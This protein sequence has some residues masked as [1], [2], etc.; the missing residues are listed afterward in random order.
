L[1]INLTKLVNDSTVLTLTKCRNLSRF[2]LIYLTWHWKPLAG[3]IYLH[4]R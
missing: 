3:P 1:L 4:L 2:V